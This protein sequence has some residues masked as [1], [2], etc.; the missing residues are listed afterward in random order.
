M[1]VHGDNAT[2][3]SNDGIAR[4]NGAVASLSLGEGRLLR[5]TDHVQWG[6]PN[7]K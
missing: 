1:Y 3:I 6:R 4:P 5:R 2:P 7:S